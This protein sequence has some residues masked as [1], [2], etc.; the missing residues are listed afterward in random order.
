MR[1]PLLD[2]YRNKGEV[3]ADH[4]LCFRYIDSTNPLLLKSE[5]S[6]LDPSSVDVQA[7]LCRTLS[8]TP[9]KDFLMTRLK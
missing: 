8:E 2:I 4:R 3:S 7:E 1:K 9:K 5:I 6:S